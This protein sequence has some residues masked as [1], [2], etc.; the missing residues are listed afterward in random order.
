MKIRGSLLVNNINGYNNIYVL[1]GS[2][3]SGKSTW[4]KKFKEEHTTNT[5]RLIT[6][7][8]VISR[9]TFRYALGDGD[10]IFDPK[11]ESYIKF[12]T[13]ELF[14]VSLENNVSNIIVDETNMSR[15]VRRN[16]METLQSAWR[17]TDY[18][19]NAVVFPDMGIDV[20]VGR[21]LGDNHGDTPRS[22]W[23]GVY[24]GLRDAYEPPTKE[25]GF[26]SI[27]YIGGD[28]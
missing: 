15:K 28:N 21:R 14:L 8:A 25:E 13:K 20:H 18:L 4:K 22:T 9:D 10:Y 27:I 16:Y 6:D 7:V 11:Y 5:D 17:R 26:D 24:R 23:E 12:I 3:A 19:Y 1:I 2:I